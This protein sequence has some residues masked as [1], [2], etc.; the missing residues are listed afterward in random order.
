MGHPAGVCYGML[1]NCSIATAATPV[2]TQR[3]AHKTQTI[4]SVRKHGLIP[5]Q[6]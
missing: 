4:S 5:K 6:T 1:K 2:T 3:V